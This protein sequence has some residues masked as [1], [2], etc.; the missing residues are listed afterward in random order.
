MQVGLRGR[1]TTPPRQQRKCLD[2]NIIGMRDDVA[3]RIDY[4]ILGMNTE[5]EEDGI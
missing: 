4:I 2:N 1:A 5:R 3:R